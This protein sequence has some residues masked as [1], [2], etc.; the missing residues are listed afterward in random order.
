MSDSTKTAA[1]EIEQTEPT[2]DELVRLLLMAPEGR[3]VADMRYEAWKQAA[4]GVLARFREDTL[5]RC[6]PRARDIPIVPRVG[7]SR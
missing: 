1:D 2:R 5:E 3:K 4:D 6:M 7:P